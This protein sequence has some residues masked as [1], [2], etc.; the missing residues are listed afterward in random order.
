MPKLSNQILIFVMRFEIS[1][2]FENVWKMTRSKEQY[3]NWIISFILTFV[4]QIYHISTNQ[5][6][7]NNLSNQKF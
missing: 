5:V 7:L 3:E 6:N 4:R 2:K 1:P